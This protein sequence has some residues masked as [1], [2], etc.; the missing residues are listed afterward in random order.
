MSYGSINTALLL[1]KVIEEIESLT[2]VGFDINK[3][4]ISIK[5]IK[6][7]FPNLS[8]KQV[9][10]ILLLIVDSYNYKTKEKTELVVTA[11]PSFLLKIKTTANI[12][13]EML[14]SANKY[15]LLTGYSISEYIDDFI[16]I[17]VGKSQMGVLVKVFINNAEKQTSIDKIFRYRSKFLQIYNYSNKDDKMSALHAK[18]LMIDDKKSLISSANL[19]YHGMEGNIEL[20]CCVESTMTA[21]K[22]DEFFKQLIFQK[23]F[24]QL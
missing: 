21:K 16:D 14:S 12:V 6:E 3:F 20:G 5:A 9:L 13:H 18:V 19:S 22:I 17:I 4:D 15:I 24:K 10:E 2:T 23:I 7:E 1:N 8:D 11:P